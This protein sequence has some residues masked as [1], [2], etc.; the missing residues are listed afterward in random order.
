MEKS[1][2]KE[3]NYLVIQAFMVNELDLKGIKLLIYAIIY[4]FSQT[5]DQEC[6]A[7]LKYFMEWT[8]STERG[9][10]KA[11]DELVQDGLIMRIN[12]NGKC[13]KYSIQEPLEHSSVPPQ[14]SVPRTP[15]HSSVPPRNSVPKTPEQS[16]AN[17]IYNINNNIKH[18]VTVCDVLDLYESVTGRMITPTIA[19]DID[20]YVSRGVELDLICHLLRE[21]ARREDIRNRWKYIDAILRENLAKGIVTLAAYVDSI[22]RNK[23]Q[24]I[25]QPGYVSVEETDKIIKEFKEMTG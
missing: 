19:E 9:V 15:E 21:V 11:I 1:K 4:G 16:S 6:T 12:E 17:N 22:A 24:P 7:S 2:I 3:N 13:N 18:T 5:I 14:N 25:R 10:R 20:N 8:N 23:K